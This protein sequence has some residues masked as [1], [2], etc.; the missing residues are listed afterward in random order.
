M[1]LQAGPPRGRP[2]GQQA[3]R[4]CNRACR[5]HGPKD[6]RNYAPYAFYAG[7]PAPP[8]QPRHLGLV[9]KRWA[10]ATDWGASPLWLAPYNC[11]A[12]RAASVDLDRAA[13]H[14]HY[15]RTPRVRTEKS[16]MDPGFPLGLWPTKGSPAGGGHHQSPERCPVRGGIGYRPVLDHC[17]GSLGPGPCGPALGPGS[18]C[19]SF[20]E[21]K[22]LTFF[23]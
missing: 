20:R 19:L 23:G 6:Q 9:A 14:P 15:P 8:L 13:G 3:R 10:Q 2:A 4:G 5:Q 21:L 11:A 12:M 16:E 17:A 7:W 22:K 1:C 18:C